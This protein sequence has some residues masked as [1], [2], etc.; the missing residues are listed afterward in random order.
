MMPYR[1]PTIRPM[2]RPAIC[3]VQGILRLPGT[4][5]QAPLQTTQDYWTAMAAP[6]M[7]EYGGSSPASVTNGYR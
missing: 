3:A 4:W 5:R 7:L 2:R 6:A 1:R